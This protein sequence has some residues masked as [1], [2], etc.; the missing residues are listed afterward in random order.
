VLLS[1]MAEAA[2]PGGRRRRVESMDQVRDPARAHVELEDV[3]VWTSERSDLLRK[4]TWRVRAGEHWALLGPNGAGKTTLL[5]V[6]GARRHPSAG[7][8]RV[9]GERLGRVDMR[10]LRRQIGVVDPALRMPDELTAEAVVLT[11]ATG[12]VQPLWDRY[13]AAEL[14]RARELL[15]LLGCAHLA[16]RR[17][18][19]CSQGERGRVRIARALM[20]SPRLLLLDEP[21]SGLDLT[22]REVLLA[23][24]GGLA[25]FEPDLATV[26]VSH[27]LEDLPAHTTHALLLAGGEVVAAGQVETALT[28]EAVS[29]CFGVEVAVRRH[30]GRWLATMAGNGAACLP[31]PEVTGTAG[32]RA[33]RW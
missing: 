8:V 16:S 32:R 17:V 31:H 18:G 24:L 3:R 4:V 30:N 7:V 10:E 21:A 23:A 11:G 26:V 2:A 29:A 15:E 1:A 22:A 5:S 28:G 14:A 6:A 19:T 27:H 33:P 13:G 9:L 20:P 25:A 12:S